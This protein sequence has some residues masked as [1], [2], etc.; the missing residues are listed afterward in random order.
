MDSLCKNNLIRQT[1]EY[2]SSESS[3]LLS[4]V[5]KVL[6]QFLCWNLNNEIMKYVLQY[7]T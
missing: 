1:E 3:L 2:H 4:K 7:G 5:H 6:I